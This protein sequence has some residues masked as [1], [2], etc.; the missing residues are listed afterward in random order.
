MLSE[1][2]SDRD[3]VTMNGHRAHETSVSPSTLRHHA[4]AGET[5]K[6]P[7]A[8]LSAA[9]IGLGLFGASFGAFHLADTPREGVLALLLEISG[10]LGML[11]AARIVTRRWLAP[12]LVLTAWILLVV[13]NSFGMRLIQRG[14]DRG[15]ELG[16]NYVTALITLEAGTWLL[17]AVLMLDGAARLWREDTRRG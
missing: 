16:F 12:S 7:A 13:G 15:L 10:W 5:L 14:T 17:V 9:L 11:A 6:G 3:S 1:Q 4:G 2:V 8:G